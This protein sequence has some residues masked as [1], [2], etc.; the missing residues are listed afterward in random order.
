M[1]DKDQDG[2]EDD[3]PRTAQRLA[4]EASA[5]SI[6]GLCAEVDAF[7]AAKPLRALGIAFLAGLIVSRLLF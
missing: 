4:S 7:I 5:E 3:P 2:I 1:P 6:A